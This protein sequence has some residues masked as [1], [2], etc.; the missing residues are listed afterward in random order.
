MQP[1]RKKNDEWAECHAVKEKKTANAM[2]TLVKIKK[3]IW[4]FWQAHTMYEDDETY[5]ILNKTTA[6]DMHW[7]YIHLLIQ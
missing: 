6:N 3:L 1:G 7:I 2:D 4:L 5:C